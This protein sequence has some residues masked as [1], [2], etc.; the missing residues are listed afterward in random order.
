[1]QNK[2]Q[3]L[4]SYR[5]QQISRSDNALPAIIIEKALTL[6]AQVKATAKSTAIEWKDI[7]PRETQALFDELEERWKEGS[8]F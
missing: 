3:S 1:M 2:N 8:L 6:S 5:S 4:Q 7:R